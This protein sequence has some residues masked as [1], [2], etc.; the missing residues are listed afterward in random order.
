VPDQSINLRSLVIEYGEFWKI[1]EIIIGTSSVDSCG[2]ATVSSLG[3]FIQSCPYVFE[4]GHSEFWE[5]ISYCLGRMNQK[6]IVSRRRG[7]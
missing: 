1:F 5:A 2:L 6:I 7:K 4:W 3:D